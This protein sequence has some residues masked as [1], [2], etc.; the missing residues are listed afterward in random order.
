M[1]YRENIK[2]ALQSIRSQLL[3]TILTALIIAIG[4]MALVGILTAI[5][6]IENSISSNF[7]AMG[8]NSFTIQNRGLHIRVGSQGRKPKRFKPIEYY[9]A[10]RFVDEYKFPSTVSV[11]TFAS[12]A[13]TIKYLQNKTN[14]N[15]FVMGGTE[16][17]LSTAGYQLA[18]GRN[19]SPTEIQFGTNVV[20]IGQGVLEKFY[21]G[22]AERI[23]KL[24]QAWE[25]KK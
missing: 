4:I 17:Y 11:S 18:E 5:D 2:V 12:R 13:S 3:R 23:F 22:N 6:A 25:E 1:D 20:I 14:P 24:Q 21:H 7:Q 8:S 15:I 16:N 9:Q 19:F 10:M